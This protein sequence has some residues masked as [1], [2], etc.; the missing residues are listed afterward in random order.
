MKYVQMATLL[1]FMMV[2]LLMVF[3]SFSADARLYGYA[4]GNGTGEQLLHEI[5]L[6]GPEDPE[7]KMLKKM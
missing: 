4:G 3:P 5:H 2:S 7:Q 6:L 1:K